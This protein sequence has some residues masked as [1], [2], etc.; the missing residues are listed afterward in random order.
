[1][2]YNLTQQQT[3]WLNS[4]P[5]IQWSHNSKTGLVS[6]VGDFDCSGQNLKDLKGIRFYDVRGN[7]DCS[8][9]LLTNLGDS[10]YW[11]VWGTFDCSQNNLTTLVGGPKWCEDAFYCNYNDLTDLEGAPWI[12]SEEDGGEFC[13][14]N[15]KLVTLSGIYHHLFPSTDLDYSDN[16]IVGF[17]KYSRNLCFKYGLEPNKIDDCWVHPKNIHRY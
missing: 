7:F 10:P 2:E 1:M 13:C 4:F 14:S 8:N 16:P 12:G 3:D 6:I 11:E 15:N 17:G 9:N 5:G